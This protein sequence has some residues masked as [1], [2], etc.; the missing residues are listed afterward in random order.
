MMRDILTLLLERWA[1]ERGEEGGGQDL[2]R[3]EREKPWAP[4]D[5]KSRDPESRRDEERRDNARSGARVKWRRKR[6]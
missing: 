4:V 6:R 1:A 5:G 3:F 2:E